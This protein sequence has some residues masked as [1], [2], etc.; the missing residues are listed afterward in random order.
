[1]EKFTVII[2]HYN[3]MK[4]IKEAI[5][6]VLK[7]KYKNIEIIIAD[8]C[9][10]EFDKKAVKKM[11]DENN[12]NNFE[13]KII[14]GRKNVGTVKN[15]NNA[16]KKVSGDYILFFASDDKLANN[17]VISN[18]VNE[19]KDKSKNIVTSQCG[20]YGNK[21]NKKLADYID[22]KSALKLNK[23]S[24]TEIY[25]KMCE[26]CFYGSGGTAYRKLVFEKYGNFNED[27]KYVEDWS[28]WLY[29]LR[30]GE[31][32]YYANFDTLCHR[33]GG[34]SHSTYTKDT[35]PPH[36]KQ[37]YKDILCIYKNEVIPYLNK[38]STKEKYR[39]LRQYN[40][41][42]LYYSCFVPSLASNIKIFDN[43]RLD[44]KK[45][46]YYWK[47]Q[48]IKRIA[49]QII[50]IDLL[51]KIKIQII[52][53][54]VVPITVLIWI[55]CCLFIINNLNIKNN[56]LL[57]LTYIFVYVALYCIIYIIDKT[58]YYFSLIV[59][60]KKLRGKNNAI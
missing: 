37:Y 1:M 22:V 17:S 31:K 54:R 49:K 32:I 46:K 34:I 60:N 19:F 9:S 18:F 58:F 13:Y 2:T 56:H 36:V 57:L 5:L 28:Y 10:K 4:Y 50:K 16:L 45:L 6:S 41:T 40:E 33:D 47:F 27:Y 29:V 24:S 43:A 39:I 42:I 44:D 15:L 12:K 59:K 25:E 21:L 52:Y 7:Q 35:I 3:Q 8:D 23:K 11:I 55:L 14:Q 30:S 53:N 26:G 51:R 20:L 48:T 38:F